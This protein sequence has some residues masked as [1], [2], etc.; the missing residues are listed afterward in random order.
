MTLANLLLAHPTSDDELLLQS[1][2]H[3]WTAGDARDRAHQLAACLSDAGLAPHTAVGL[4]Q[5][6]NVDWIPAMC[7]IWLAGGV[8][9]PVN[10]RLPDRAAAS[11]LRDA[12]VSMLVDD[13]SVEPLETEPEALDHDAAFILWTSGTTGAPKPILHRHTEYLT[14]ID[15]VLGVL[16][17]TRDTS[18]MPSPNLIPVSMALNAG[19]YNSLF[20]LRA[21]APLVFMDR[22]SGN[23]FAELIREHHIRSTVLPPAAITMLNEDPDIEDLSPLRYVRSI[24]APLSAFQARRFTDKFA[25]NV[26]NGYGQAELGEVI[27][28]TAPEARAHPE[29]IGSI[30]RPHPGVSIKILEPDDNAVGMLAIKPAQPPAPTVLAS[31]GDRVLDDGFIDTGDLARSDDDGFVWIEG[32]MSDLIN[33]GGNKVF[34]AEVEEVLES[35]P[36]VKEAAVA[37]TSDHR[38]GEVPVAYVVGDATDEEMFAACRQNLVPYKI[39]VRF[40][41]LD[42]LPRNDAGKILRRE[43]G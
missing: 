22:F 36:G 18:K 29:K 33:R 6:H 20:G 19:I 10:P 15:R 34:P 8:I 21:G 38:L 31:L 7:G 43:L 4:R 39:P 42:A 32:R 25:V 11:T 27:G 14:L 30:G 12:S 3:C 2:H 24:T 23:E 35:M 1:R 5:R 26:L 17:S 28:W 16:A 41:S 37:G 40:V 13:N 9:V